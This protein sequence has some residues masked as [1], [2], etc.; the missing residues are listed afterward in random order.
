MDLKFFVAKTAGGVQEG[1]R[2]GHI[3]QGPPEE[4]CE[5]EVFRH[6]LLHCVRLLANGG[7]GKRS[8]R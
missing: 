6:E 3:H 4:R 5:I 1:A 2:G 8:E 7:G